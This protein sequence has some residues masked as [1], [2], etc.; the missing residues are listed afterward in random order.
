M[1]HRKQNGWRITPTNGTITAPQIHV[2]V[3]KYEEAV[4]IAKERSG[5]SRFKSWKFI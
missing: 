5:L 1:Q 2:D 4:K 3:E